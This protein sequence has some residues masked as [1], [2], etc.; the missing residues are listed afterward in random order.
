MAFVM[1]RAFAAACAALL[2]AAGAWT[3][4][5]LRAP[6]PRAR[7]AWTGGAAGPS[8]NSPVDVTLY[9]PAC[10]ISAIRIHAAPGQSG[11]LTTEVIRGG[12]AS[13]PGPSLSTRQQ[14]PF[15][16]QG[17][18]DVPLDAS[19]ARERVR[20]RLWPQTP[21]LALDAARP[22]SLVPVT[23]S[24]LGLLPCSVDG[25][26]GLAWTVIALA[27]LHLAGLGWLAATVIVGDG[28]RREPEVTPRPG[29]AGPMAAVGIVTTTLL[30]YANV[31]PPFEPPDE[32]AHLQ[33]ARYVARTGELPSAIPPVDSEWR[34]SVYE[35]VQQPAYYLLAAGVIRVTGDAASAPAPEVHPQSRLAGGPDVN[36]YRHPDTT[37]APGALRALWTL[38]LLSVL[39]AMGTVWCAA[40]A[41]T[42]ATGNAR[43]GA[44]SAA[45]LALVPQWAAVMGIV[46]TDPPATLAAAVATLL[47]CRLVQE[48]DHRPRAAVAGVVTGLA[49]AFKATSVFLVPMAAAA[50]VTVARRRGVRIAQRQ[51]IAFAAGLLLAA[52]WI[53]LRAWLVFGDPLARAF[54]R[55]VLAIGGF[56]VTEGPP[57]FSAAFVEQL[58]LMVF[59][60]FW[61][62]FGSLGAGP[63]PGTRLWWVYGATTFGL[64]V[65]LALGAAWA[66]WFTWSAPP[67]TDDSR[68]ASM[69]VVCATGVMIGVALWAWV[70]LVPQADVVVHWTPRHVLPLTVPL[71][72]VVASGLQQL[73]HRVRASMRVALRVSGGV[74]ILVLA[75]TGL[76]VFRSVVLGFHFGY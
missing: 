50:L 44:A 60:A 45:A 35:W 26:A 54:K 22:F 55:E 19:P 2:L 75:V 64:L 59:E 71:L 62:R 9:L 67:D 61:A 8:T 43:L 29:G 21:G 57:V 30:L 18:I 73:A 25:R 42:L 74:A 12:D 27:G 31:V 5:S 52:A 40:R 65:L 76:A 47:L 16:G 17:L 58:R 39:M 7:G 68:R 15:D 72:V 70:N 66:A 13:G 46:S 38:R 23:A 48:A 56:V 28:A 1:R 6:D 24:P 63:L 4:G 51:A 14:R 49:Y 41:V 33:F 32:L 37:S 53:P 34:S 69:V 36:I 10:P 20:L 3:L 11:T